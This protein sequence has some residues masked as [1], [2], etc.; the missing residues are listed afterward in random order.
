MKTR[1]L[2]RAAALS[3]ICFAAP[4]FA[5][6][7]AN[8]E[9]ATVP[10]AAVA[11]P[12]AA[13]KNEEI[14][15]ELD[16][17][18][19]RVRERLQ[20]GQTS[21]SDLAEELKAF[22]ALDAKYASEKSEAAAMI[23]MMK[24]MLYIQ[25]LE[26]AEQGVAILKGVAT[27]FPDTRMAGQIPQMIERIEKQ[28]ATEAATAV[29][30]EFAPF[31][32]PATDGTTVDLAAYR[33]KI[34]LIDFWATWCGPCVDEL[35]H[36]KEA[37]DKFHDKG[38]EIIGISLDK[39]GDKLA[40]FTKDKQMTWPQI[41]DGQG[42]QN[43]LAQAYGISSIPATY[44]LDKEGKIAAKNLRGEALSKKVAELLAK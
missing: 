1:P 9:P 28:A 17:L 6:A 36:V 23:R 27:D 15:K 43:K 39:D 26:K 11:S 10:A 12:A 13:S 41:F 32:E 18:I 37:Y 14:Q 38:F 33:G 19:G 20:K 16:A 44:L 30:K 5:Q 8:T 24:A 25:V 35:P 22:D 31:K 3:A 4:L 2:V 40:A 7:P 34:V 29:G 42:W 21:E